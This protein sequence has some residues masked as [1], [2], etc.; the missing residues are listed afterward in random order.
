MGKNKFVTWV[1]LF[2]VFTLFVGS[3]FLF[4]KFSVFQPNLIKE[5]SGRPAENLEIR[6]QVVNFDLG[7]RNVTFSFDLGGQVSE[8]TDSFYVYS[9]YAFYAVYIDNTS[10]KEGSDFHQLSRFNTN[11]FE[12]WKVLEII[13]VSTSSPGKHDLKVVVATLPKDLWATQDTRN[14][15]CG[16][17]GVSSDLDAG[18]YK[19]NSVMKSC[20]YEPLVGGAS[21]TYTGD[22]KNDLKTK[23][24]CEDNYGTIYDT[25]SVSYVKDVKCG[26]E[27][28][29]TT[30]ESA[31]S[32][33]VG[34][35]NYVCRYDSCVVTAHF[36][37]T[38][39]LTKGQAYYMP[40]LVDNPVSF[41]NYVTTEIYKSCTL[42]EQCNPHSGK[43]N[44]TNPNTNLFTI[45]ELKKDFVVCKDQLCAVT[46]SQE[47][48]DALLARISSL[49]T[50]LNQK[51]ALI[52]QLNASIEEKA[53]LLEILKLNAS[54]QADAIEA[55]SKTLGD[56]IAYINQLTDSIDRK[57]EIIRELELSLSQQVEMVNQLTTNVNEKAAIISELNL[58]ISQQSEFIKQLTAKFEEQG[59]IV[60]KLE[61]NIQEKIDLIKSL[62][63]ENDKQ[64][65]IVSQLELSLQ[66]KITLINRLTSNNEEQA[67]LIKAMK[68]SFKDQADI[69]DGLDKRISD[70]AIL[71]GSLT[72]SVDE[73]GKI[74]AN[75]KLTISEQAELIRHLTKNNEEQGRIIANL[76]LSTQQQA[77]LIKKLAANNEEMAKIIA[78]MK[79][80]SDEEQELVAKLKMTIQEQQMLLDLIRSEK[81]K[82]INI[83]PV[84]YVVIVGIVIVLG[85]IILWIAKKK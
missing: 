7:E 68:L 8:L 28:S 73:Q 45:V 14:G 6:N 31:G 15:V 18:C 50:N 52:N 20:N 81:P 46:T 29:T 57:G 5:G 36:G 23:K 10:I 22:W 34:E 12:K 39:T 21:Y 38:I 54:A 78:N 65:R 77:D 4:T 51:I 61:L 47:E 33:R 84:I 58:S 79:L 59:R 9:T 32:G 63:A 83:S 85:A 30:L 11:I 55:L 40:D 48:Y 25:C 17:F 1:L 60:N 49:E 76:K 24:I 27:S 26:V 56:K 53:K 69:I 66:E 16:Y 80:S 70:E 82:G 43:L 2:I 71:I 62:T 67:N 3:M 44:T 41:Y 13:D 75:L 74:M 19:I 42:Q 64:A 35:A 72:Q 37:N